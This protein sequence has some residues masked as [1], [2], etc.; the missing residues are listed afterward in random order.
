MKTTSADTAAAGRGVAD[1]TAAGQGRTQASTPSAELIAEF[2]GRLAS[3]GGDDGRNA[4]S[5]ARAQTQP[6]GINGPE[7]QS[8]TMPAGA[9]AMDA[10]M[11]RTPQSM[12]ASTELPVPTPPA[13]TSHTE[14]AGGAETAEGGL[15]SAGQPTPPG[16]VAIT[17]EATPFVPSNAAAFA[18]LVERHVR[19][20]L[21]SDGGLDRSGSRMLFKLAD[22]SAGD[23]D[24]TLIRTDT[25]WLLEASTD[26]QN[27]LDNLRALS[28]ALEARFAHLRLGEVEVRASLRHEGQTGLP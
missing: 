15:M 21:V 22:T 6:P 10:A 9:A 5:G 7:R 12:V 26:S 28:P 13:A 23:T 2:R 25:G 3:R 14:L 20:M 17:A 16:P 19:F 1:Q 8:A 18:A 4:Q 11:S 24:L 27:T